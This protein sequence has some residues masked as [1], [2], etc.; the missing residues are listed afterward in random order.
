MKNTDGAERNLEKIKTMLETVTN[1][2][3]DDYQSWLK[4]TSVFRNH[5]FNNRILIWM[6]GGASVMGAKQWEKW[7][8]SVKPSEKYNPI[9]I[10]APV[11]VKSD[12]KV[13]RVNPETGKME[14]V[15][16]DRT[17]LIGF[18]CVK[19][20]DIKQTTGKPLPEVMTKRS[21]IDLS[22]LLEVAT[23][24]GFKIQYQSMEF[25][26]GGC[27]YHND[28]NHHN[29][30]ALN[31]NRAELDKIGTLLHELSHGLLKHHE[32]RK[33]V[34]TPQKECEAETLTFLL[35]QEYGVERQSQFY[36]KS[37]GMKEDIFKSFVLIDK[38]MNAFKKVFARKEV[39]EKVA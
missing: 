35:C 21:D 34:P 36:L 22:S 37:W 28:D 1:M 30:I 27:L 33:D 18:K 14:E 25:G 10:L 29:D 16:D 32:E 15:D 2:S 4:A 38:G 19:V 39:K 9:W 7:E 31:S 20:Y 13:N 5:S 17:I 23:T 3:D 24:L 8:R 6:A 12:H 11:I 26:K